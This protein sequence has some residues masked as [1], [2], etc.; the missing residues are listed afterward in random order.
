[1]GTFFTVKKNRK[2]SRALDFYLHRTAERSCTF[3][4]STMMMMMMVIRSGYT[5]HCV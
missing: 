5:V 2:K 3:F 1:M 4:F